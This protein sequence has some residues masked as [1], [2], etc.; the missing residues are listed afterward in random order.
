MVGP[1]GG[2]LLA[3]PDTT[4]SVLYVILDSKQNVAARRFKIGIVVNDARRQN[5]TQTA[6]DGHMEFR[7]DLQYKISKA[8]VLI[9][10]FET[11]GL[12]NVL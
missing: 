8:A 3:T 12:K 2:L 1:I 4:T 9:L 10:K 5:V 6:H 11:S 7:N